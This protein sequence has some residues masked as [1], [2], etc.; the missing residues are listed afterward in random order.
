[1]SDE[2]LRKGDYVF[3]DNEDLEQRCIVEHIRGTDSVSLGTTGTKIN[4]VP[5]DG[6]G[7]TDGELTTIDVSKIDMKLD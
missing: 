7:N 1:M 2:V 6:M 4:V 3:V 5:T